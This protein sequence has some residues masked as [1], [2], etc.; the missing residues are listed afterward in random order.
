[1]IADVSNQV[2]GGDN[3]LFG[4]MIESFLKD[5][6]QPL[7]AGKDLRYGVSVTDKCMSWERTQPLFEVM[8][9]AVRDRRKQAK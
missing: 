4:V 7:N 3:N 5:G 8:A 2:A 9:Q 6:N 1:V